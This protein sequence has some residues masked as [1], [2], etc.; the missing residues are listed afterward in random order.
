VGAGL[1]L[2]HLDRQSITHVELF[3]PGIELP[4]D[5]VEYPLPRLTMWKVVGGCISA[6]PHPQLYYMMILVLIH[7][8]GTGVLALR[9]PTALC[10]VASVPLIYALGARE[11][12]KATGLVAA[13][14][15]ALNGP[16]GGTTLDCPVAERLRLASWRGDSPERVA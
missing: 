1:R 2:F 4:V 11:D 6:E 10:G 14:M 7:V 9:L 15:L 5:L 16:P 8:F 12:R 3:V 13:A